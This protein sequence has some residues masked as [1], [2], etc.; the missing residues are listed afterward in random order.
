MSTGEDQNHGV[1]TATP[2]VKPGVYSPI[3]V[4]VN[5]TIGSVFLG[6]VA[7][8]LL[9]ALLRAEVRNR[10]LQSQLAGQLDPAQS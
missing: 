9:I 8:V 2:N 6:I 4:H 10:R 1:K 5:E 3:N 7:L